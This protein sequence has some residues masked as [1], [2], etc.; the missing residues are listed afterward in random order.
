MSLKSYF[1]LFEK[2][3][4]LIYL[5]NA[6]STQKPS[7]VIDGVSEYV[8]YDYANIHRGMYSLSEKSEFLYHQSKQFLSDLIWSNAKEIIY[9]YNSTYC[10]N[11]LAQ[12]LVNSKKLWKWG[13]VLL[14]M[15]EHHSNVLTWQTLSQQYWFQ[16]KFV[17]VNDD[18]DI[19]RIDF[20]EKY[21]E[22]VKVVS[23]SH[24]SNVTGAIID[25]KKVKSF[26]RED[27]FFIIDGSQSVPHFP[28][29]VTE[30][31]CDAM[32]MTAHKMMGFT[33]LGMLFLK[34][35][36]IKDLTPMILW[37]WTVKDVSQTDFSLQWNSDK[38]EAG[39]PNIIWGVSLLKA[40]EF[41][42]SIGWIS[43]IWNHE[44]LLVSFA[45]KEFKKRE[46]KVRV[47]WHLN[48]QRRVGVYSFVMKEWNT[49][50]NKIGELFAENGIC[51][52]AGGHCAY[53]LHKFLNV[54]GSV[55]MSSYLY[56]DISDLQRFFEVL[57]I[58]I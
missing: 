11:L 15:W 37:G 29:N 28:V 30:L 40:L 55:R 2:H 20:S 12:A 18:T 46:E 22:S 43:E 25:M 36:W 5:D 50:F 1:P 17:E 4:E 26:L 23:F 16:I 27:T 3:P 8:A 47:L 13:V 56:N 44:L 57:D 10:F 42:Q 9:S 38:R 14:G 49:N 34:H 35:Q 54:G 32:I 6:A 48:D 51:I 21:D 19:D 7:L 39:T 45:N 52:R 53:P 31:W 41:I 33:G 58:I 24:V